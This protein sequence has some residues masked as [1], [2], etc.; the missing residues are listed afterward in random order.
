M[1]L[2]DFQL[3]TWIYISTQL[4]EEFLE[5]EARRRIFYE[6]RNSIYKQ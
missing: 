1:E 3:H 5:N 4:K 2:T 6:M